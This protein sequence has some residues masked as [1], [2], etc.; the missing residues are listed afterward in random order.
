MSLEIFYVFFVKWQFAYS[1]YR[2]VKS[3]LFSS[4]KH[5]KIV[6]A[7]GALPLVTTNGLKLPGA[8]QCPIGPSCVGNMYCQFIKQWPAYAFFQVFKNLIFPKVLGNPLALY[9]TCSI[10]LTARWWWS[11]IIINMI[12]T[13]HL[14]L[15]IIF[16][17]LS[18]STN[19]Y[20]VTSYDI[21][22]YVLMIECHDGGPFV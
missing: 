8:T 11:F 1:E 21:T 10:M 9:I 5:L 7:F 20:D 14:E 17:D 18:D 22:V 13:Y 16:H 12:I 15:S 19:D 3:Y 6:A 4:L 2:A